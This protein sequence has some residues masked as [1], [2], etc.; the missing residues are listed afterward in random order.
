MIKQCR[1]SSTCMLWHRPAISR[2]INCT[3]RVTAASHSP[4]FVFSPF[5]GCLAL[6]CEECYLVQQI[7]TSQTPHYSYLTGPDPLYFCCSQL[8][9]KWKE[10]VPIT[11]C[12]VQQATLQWCTLD[13]QHFGKVFDWK[14]RLTEA[15]GKNRHVW[16]T[17][18]YAS[19]LVSNSHKLIVIMHH[20]I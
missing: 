15:T 13:F 6:W 7:T 2:T 3:K 11:F 9:F 12:T 14:N 16:T 10:L 4:R 18:V 5:E 8:V 17:H 1:D 20:S 19:I